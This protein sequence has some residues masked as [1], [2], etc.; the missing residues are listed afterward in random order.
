VNLEG[1]GGA[2]L[3]RRSSAEK[4]AYLRALGAGERNPGARNP[5]SMARD[6]VAHIRA[7]RLSLRIAARVNAFH[8][9]ARW[10]FER[11]APG[12]YWAEIARVKHF[13]RILLEEVSAGVGQVVIMGAGLDSRPYRLRAELEGVRLFEVDHPL[14]ASL[15]RERLKA[16]FGEVPGQIAYVSVDLAEED[17]GEALAASGF[18]PS[19]P[20]LILWVGVAMYLPAKAVVDQLEWVSCRPPSSSVAFDYFD[21][22]FFGGG[23]RMRGTWRVRRGLELSGERLASGF[24]PDAM[25]ALV[26]GCGL[27]VKSHLGPA[28]QEEAYLGGGDGA[29]AG[30]VVEYAHFLHAGV[31]P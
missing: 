8:R 10:A 16:V 3:T 6:F 15:K 2:R 18:D 28:E 21:R 29:P 23:E 1:A 11:I 24:E 4:V 13:D 22:A 17:P 30:R 25:P 19:S 26:A 14:T 20:V 5:D 7:A 31:A 27:A 9:T 12:A